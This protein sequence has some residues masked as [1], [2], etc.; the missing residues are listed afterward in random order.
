MDLFHVSE[1]DYVRGQTLGPRTALSPFMVARKNS[2]KWFV[3]RTLYRARPRAATLRLRAYY[4]CESVA[5]C[6]LYALAEQ[7][8]GRLFNP[9]Y[10]RVELNSRLRAPM[11]LPGAI[12]KCN[13]EARR[14]RLAHAYWNPGPGWEYWEYLGP[15]MTIVDVLDAQPIPKAWGVHGVHGSRL[16]YANDWD[17][18]DEIV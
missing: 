17:R 14:T 13:D 11:V 9:R 7:G 16:R 2:G 18:A 5:D 3:E 12:A 1:D 4:A 10:Y 15:T 6:M 8:H